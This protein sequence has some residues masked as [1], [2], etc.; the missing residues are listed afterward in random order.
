MHILRNGYNTPSCSR[1]AYKVYSFTKLIS[2][3]FSINQPF[4]INCSFEPRMLHDT[5]EMV[6]ISKVVYPQGNCLAKKFAGPGFARG[7]LNS[8]TFVEHGF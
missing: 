6:A 3:N 8:I 1:A 4:K 5:A 2:Y 7:H